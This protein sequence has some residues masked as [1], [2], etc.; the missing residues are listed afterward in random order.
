MADTTV[1]PFEMFASNMEALGIPP[2]AARLDCFLR[3]PLETQEAIVEEFLGPP[4]GQDDPRPAGGEG[5]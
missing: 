3:L 4:P 1:T 5:V 2:G